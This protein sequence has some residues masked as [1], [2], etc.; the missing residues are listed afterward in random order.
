MVHIKEIFNPPPEKQKILK[1]K[2]ITQNNQ[3]KP[4]EASMSLKDHLLRED[5]R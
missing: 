3:S 2:K 4:L 5:C 1:K